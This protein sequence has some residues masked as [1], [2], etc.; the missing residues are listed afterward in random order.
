MPGSADVTNVVLMSA[1]SDTGGSYATGIVDMPQMFWPPNGAPPPSMQM[2]PLTRCGLISATSQ[3]NGPPAEWVMMMAG[4]ILSSSIAPRCR[5]TMCAV[6]A[7]PAAPPSTG[8]G[9]TANAAAGAPPCGA[10]PCEP[11]PPRPPAGAAPG[12]TVPP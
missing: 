4:P 6:S 11:R 10:P 7:P 8:G 5:H 1:G 12:D 3:P 9:G 2:M